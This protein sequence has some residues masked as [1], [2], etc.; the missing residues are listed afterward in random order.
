MLPTF[1]MTPLAAFSAFLS[2][3]VGITIKPIGLKRFAFGSAVVTSVGMLGI[4][5]AFA[6]FT[7]FFHVPLLVLI[8]AIK[9]KPTVV[10]N[11]IVIRPMININVTADHR[12]I[13]GAEGGR[14]IKLVERLFEN[15]ED[16]ELDVENL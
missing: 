7:P 15:P 8:G 10:D 14:L 9:N 5:D 13:D 2:N 6:T 3:C 16:I 4:E 11:Q 12:Y 1:L